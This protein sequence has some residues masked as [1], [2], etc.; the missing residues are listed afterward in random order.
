MNEELKLILE[1]VG[2][3]LTLK[4]SFIADDV[5]TYK[6]VIPIAVKYNGNEDIAFVEVSVFYDNNK[7]YMCYEQIDEVVNDNQVFEIKFVSINY[8]E[9]SIVVYQ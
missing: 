5:I 2:L 4:F 6:S 9:E 8:K 1:S 3:D 7:S